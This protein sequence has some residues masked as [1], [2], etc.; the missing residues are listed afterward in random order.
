MEEFATSTLSKFYPDSLKTCAVCKETKY[1]ADF[2][3]DCKRP[4][5]LRY[6]CR[7]CEN[8]QSAI[9]R[10]ALRDRPSEDVKKIQEE[11]YPGG[12]KLCHTCFQEKD[13]SA[14]GKF[15]NFVGLRHHCKSCQREQT[16]ECMDKIKQRTEEE[17]KRD[18]E[19]AYPDGV[20][21]CLSC[22]VVKNVEE[23]P[24]ESRLRQFYTARCKKCVNQKKEYREESVRK[25]R[26]ENMPDGTKRC[27]FCWKKKPFDQFA[28]STKLKS[29]L[30]KTC[31]ECGDVDK[32]DKDKFLEERAR[33]RKE[34]CKAERDEKA[35]EEASLFF[36]FIIK[37]YPHVKK[38]C[39]TCSEELPLYLF[40]YNPKKKSKLD[41]VCQSCL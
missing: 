7:D 30:E 16:Y 25:Y 15:A 35:S 34:V 28:T 8:S 18:I 37:Q 9:L 38:Y 17:I 32:S 14:F 33:K 4:S 6:R 24:T 13:I 12:K 27:G 10:R 5:L 40:P 2:G 21:S 41:D 31:I 1:V 39:L 29:G 23:F 20:K 3:V 26:E 22:D 36:G 19:E 11:V